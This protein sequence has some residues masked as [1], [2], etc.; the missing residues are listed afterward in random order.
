MRE[1]GTEAKRKKCQKGGNEVAKIP[2]PP[3][4]LDDFRLLNSALAPQPTYPP[5]LLGQNTKLKQ[6]WKI[7]YSEFEASWLEWLTAS[8]ASESS[9]LV[10]VNGR[11]YDI[12]GFMHR[13][14]GSLETLLDNAGRDAT[15]LFEDVGH[16]LNARDLMKTL[17]SIGPHFSSNSGQRAGEES[18]ESRGSCILSSTARRLSERRSLA[19]RVARMNS[20]A[21]FQRALRTKP[22]FVAGREHEFICE[23]CEGAFE[24]TDLD[25]DGSAGREKRGV[26]GHLSGSLRVFYSPV[27]GEWGYFY[28]CCRKTM[29]CFSC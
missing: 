3:E 24:P 9:C 14:P 15:E 22:P 12:T 28:S 2:E 29:C 16:S 1:G 18:G 27:R 5:P 8:Q 25:G 4:K 13:H 20:S 6:G 21:A 17:C 26:C 11:L 23:D 7:F 10:G 19:W